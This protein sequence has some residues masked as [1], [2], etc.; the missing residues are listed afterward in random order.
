MKKKKKKSQCNE[1]LYLE[2][3]INNKV[4]KVLVKRKSQVSSYI[5]KVPSSI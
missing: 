3:K 2:V 5:G 4:S 1:S